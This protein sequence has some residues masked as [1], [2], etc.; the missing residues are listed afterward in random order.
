M[1][2]KEVIFPN[3]DNLNSLADFHNKGGQLYDG[4]PIVFERNYRTPLID[5]ILKSWQIGSVKM[6]ITGLGKYSESSCIVEINGKIEKIPF[7]M[8][9]VKNETTINKT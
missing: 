1:E 6:D 3:R 4:M 2:Y 7:T 9:Y 5:C 8:L